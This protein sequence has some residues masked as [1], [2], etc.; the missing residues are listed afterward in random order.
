MAAAKDRWYIPD[1]NRAIDLEK[2]REKSLLKEFEE[3]RNTKKKLKVFRM[4]AMRAGFKHY[5]QQREYKTIIEV[6]RKIPEKILQEDQ[7]LL[8]FYDNAV[9]RAGEE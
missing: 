8:M 3:Y 2:L 9:T 5:F 7:K 6:A 4:E 1:P